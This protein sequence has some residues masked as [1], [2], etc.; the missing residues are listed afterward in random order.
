MNRPRCRASQRLQLWQPSFTSFNPLPIPLQ[1]LRK[2][3][4]LRSVASS[5]LATYGSGLSAF[6]LF[7]DSLN[8]PEVQ[9]APASQYLVTSFIAHLAGHYSA[10][11]IKNYIYGVKL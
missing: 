1:L 5:T 8:I 11:T 7:C 3:I 10:Q 2:N 9:R 6:H 4:L